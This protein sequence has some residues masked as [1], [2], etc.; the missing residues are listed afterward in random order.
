MRRPTTWHVNDSCFFFFFCCW[1]YK[2]IRA[3]R[4]NGMM[5]LS[6]LIFVTFLL[7]LTFIAFI[8]FGVF[9]SVGMF[10]SEK[11]LSFFQFSDN[12]A[13]YK[14]LGSEG[15]N[16]RSPSAINL[17]RNASINFIIGRNLKKN[18]MTRMWATENDVILRQM[19]NQNNEYEKK[20]KNRQ[21]STTRKKLPSARQNL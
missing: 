6:L 20:N 10:A 19:I 12:F 14:G 4:M 11:F 3:N 17:I 13:D 2:L 15:E 9:C 5:L 18:D 16:F 8:F 1:I 7:I 21:K